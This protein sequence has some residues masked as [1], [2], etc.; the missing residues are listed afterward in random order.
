[1]VF[2]LAG[3]LAACN[4]EGAPDAA[5]DASASPTPAATGTARAESLSNGARSVAEETDDFLFEYAYPAEAG[6]IP[7][8][9]SV[10]DVWLEQRREE[11]AGESVEA[12]REA[13]GEGFPY[14]KHS[15]TAEWRVVADLP[16]YLSLSA[17]IATY[18][19]GAHGNS[20]LQ[21]LVWDKEAEK[22]MDAIRL[23]ISPAALEEAL[24][25]RFCD[26]LGR[27]REKRREAESED[28]HGEAEP[29][30][31]TSFTDCPGIE[32]LEVLVGSS[33]GR[34]FNRLTLYAGPYVAGP[35]AEGAYEIGLPVDQAVLAAVKPE[36]REAFSAR[37]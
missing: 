3:A 33:N 12:R 7:E 1:M 21:S 22:A 11:L 26:A 5:V 14:N 24:G 15:Y 30:E 17:D 2:A 9:A 13:R 34:T 25:D 18:S 37:N 16:G 23:F 31:G 36:Y 8:L 29:D 10:L 28:E 27:E 19:G 35:Y 32:E 4:G 6:R 20:T